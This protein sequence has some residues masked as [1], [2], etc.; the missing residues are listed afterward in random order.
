M[1]QLWHLLMPLTRVLLVSCNVTVYVATRKPKHFL[2]LAV[3][4]I[5]V[6]QKYHSDLAED[7]ELNRRAS[8]ESNLPEG[9]TFTMANFTYANSAVVKTMFEHL[10]NTTFHGIGVS[11]CA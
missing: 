11:I 4:S 5:V 2:K 8:E 9:E 6:V 7:E 1:K 3:S 10:Q